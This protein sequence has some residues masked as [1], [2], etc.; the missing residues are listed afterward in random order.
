VMLVASFV[1]LMVI[2]ALQSWQRKRAG[3][4]S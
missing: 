2:N 4:S 1:L 3:A